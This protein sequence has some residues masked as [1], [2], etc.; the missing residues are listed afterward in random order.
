MKKLL[1]L[2]LAAVLLA[3]TAAGAMAAVTVSPNYVY[4]A[5][6]DLK[7]TQDGVS[8]I[9]C[10]TSQYTKEEIDSEPEDFYAGLPNPGSYSG[11]E[12]L[13][14]FTVYNVISPDLVDAVYYSNVPAAIG[15]AAG[16]L[17]LY[18]VNEDFTS[19]DLTTKAVMSVSA[20]YDADKKMLAVKPLPS[21]IGESFWNPAQGIGTRLILVKGTGDTPTPT[22]D[23]T[24]PVVTSADF[25]AQDAVSSDVKFGYEG[26]SF[27]VIPG[28]DGYGT[29]EKVTASNITT[30]L[31]DN[32]KAI[33]LLT[34]FSM[35]LYDEEN[36]EYLDGKVSGDV[37]LK[38]QLD[39]GVT[40]PEGASLYALIPVYEG[41]FRSSPLKSAQKSSA[42]AA[43][44]GVKFSAF[45]AEY[46]KDTKTVTFTASGIYDEAAVVLAAVTAEETPTPDPEP[47]PSG[48]SSSGCSAGFGAL[49][50]LALAPLMIRRKK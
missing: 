25:K 47:T 44:D 48:S 11:G 16:S 4:D 49:A 17:Y 39:P 18:F 5:S 30:G 43:G 20:K 23:P 42:L 50:L 35:E 32:T 1:V 3:V 7:L 28:P 34:S 37:A 22:P 13:S 19:S 10:G 45:P 24:D 31:P 27:D 46:D 33:S 40:V 6:F 26:A 9:E 8:D 29:E 15:D 12:I 21:E 41:V 36:D 2:M 14:V 38:F